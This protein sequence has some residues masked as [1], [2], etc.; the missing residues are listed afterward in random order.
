MTRRFRSEVL[1]VAVLL[2]L[3]VAADAAAQDEA[4][5]APD[6]EPRFATEI[7]VTPERGAAPRALVPAATT[8]LDRP[9]LDTLPM[10]HAGEIPSF[11]PGFYAARPEFHSGR[12]IV[13]ARGFFG[14]GEAEYVLLLVDGLPMSDIESGLMDWSVVSFSAVQRV[15]ASRGPGASLYGDSAIGGVIQILTVRPASGGRGSI[16]GGSFGTFVGDGAYGRR[17]RAGGFTASGAVRRTDGALEQSA[18][19]QALGALGAD[20]Q[21]GRFAWQWGFSADDR[22]RED[23]GALA[24]EALR[25][26]PTGSDPLYR[27]DRTDRRGLAATV[28]MRHDSSL[29]RP[30]ARLRVS[31][32]EEDSVRTI[33][34]APGFGDRR[35]RDLSGLTI[36][37]SLEGEH[38]WTTAR[39]LVMRFGLDLAR[40]RLDTGYRSVSDEGATGALN[41]MASGRRVRA[42]VFASSLV[43][44][45]P[46]VRVSAAIRWDGVD[47]DGFN[48]SASAA[49]DN[50]RA[51]SPRAG[52]A[53]RLSDT[54]NVSLF[55]QVSKAFKAPTLDQRFDPRPYP[56]FRGGTFTISNPG[57][58][59]QRAA[60]ME[61]GLSGSGPVRWN[62]LAY[63]M[64]VEDEIDFDL[65]TFSY[66]N[67]GESRHTGV[68]IEA[69]GQWWTRFQPSVWYAFSRVVAAGS[70]RQ[71]KNVPRHV[72]RVAGRGRLPGSIDAHVRSSHAT[73]SSFDDDGLF[74]IEGASTIDL[75]VRRPIG[76]YAVFVDALNLGDDRYE[77]VP[78]L[79]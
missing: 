69:E 62:A 43:D 70:D 50:Q 24:R 12:P 3:L 5:P 41:S 36:G 73:G 44:V 30:Q 74:P 76:R 9:L 29:V 59:P 18:A 72:L 2:P 20:W 53:V 57:L 65:R 42:G 55:G 16:S 19:R 47:D 71:L 60:N 11:L 15:E 25:S 46:R 1:A 54:G 27:F 48:T 31:W 63:H 14:G 13:S 51:W 17:V 40:E 6:G 79:F 45:A 56:D 58:V 32:R 39:P 7:V 68:E 61:V 22:D 33:L 4:Q 38:A 21:A 26:D 10:A 75:R 28:T 64:A 78:A 37:G 34:L 67:I 77:E 49:P 8:V 66:A 52:V 35:A 23:A